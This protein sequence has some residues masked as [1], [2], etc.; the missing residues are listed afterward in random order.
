[1]SDGAPDVRMS[2][3]P[4]TG[5]HFTVRKCPS[6]PYVDNSGEAH[7]ELF[8]VEKA[9]WWD[10]A[11][12]ARDVRLRVMVTVYNDSIDLEA[13]FESSEMERIESFSK[14][15]DTSSREKQF[16]EKRSDQLRELRQRRV[17]RKHNHGADRPVT[18]HV[19]ESLQSVQLWIQ[20]GHHRSLDKQ[21][22]MYYPNI[23]ELSKI[24]A[25]KNNSSDSVLRSLTTHRRSSGNGSAPT[26]RFLSLSPLKC[27]TQN[28]VHRF[29]RVTGAGD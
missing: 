28:F 23:E 26:W 5:V 9:H 18:Y 19:V 6:K 10:I 21:E 15:R 1:M 3:V 20:T 11:A 2:N 12:N 7:P 29:W 8:V 13:S 14:T 24:T 25:V 22:R 17:W 4:Y 27:L 16:S